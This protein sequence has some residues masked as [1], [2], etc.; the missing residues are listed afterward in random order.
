MGVKENQ[1]EIK[2]IE[3][4]I[5]HLVEMFE[6]ENRPIVSMAEY[7]SNDIEVCI[8]EPKMFEFSHIKGDDYIEVDIEDF[9]YVKVPIDSSVTAS[10]SEYTPKETRLSFPLFSKT[11]EFNVYIRDP[12]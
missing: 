11:G 4:K 6:S 3:I 7:R 8:P 2:I 12:K 9:I 10:L 1:V 5:K